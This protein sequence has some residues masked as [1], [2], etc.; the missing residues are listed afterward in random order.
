MKSVRF[1]ASPVLAIKLPAWRS[2]LVL[3]LLFTAFIALL[4]R[5]I[6]LQG[7]STDFLQTQGEMRYAR[8][9]D[10]PATRGKITD[11]NGEVLASSVPAWAIWAIPEDVELPRDKRTELARLLGVPAPELQKKLANEDRKFVYLKRQVSPATADAIAQL[12]LPGIHQRKEYR[13]FYP[14]GETMAHVVGFTNVEDT[15]QEGIE[16]AWQKSLAGQPGSRRVIK[17]RLGRVVE[18]VASIRVPHDGHDLTLSIDGKIQYL[19]FSHLKAAVEANRAKAGAIVVID[20]ETGEVLALANLPSYN[21]NDRKDLTG[22]QLR[23][24]VLTDTFEPGS[25]LKPF[26]IALALEHG[27]VKPDTVVQTA[28]GKMTIGSATISDSHAHGPLTVED[29]I[30]VSSN[31]GTAKVA[32]RMEPRE[33]WEMYTAAGFGQAPKWGFPGAVAGRVRPYKSWRPIEQA[34]MAYGY[35]LS[36]SLVQIARAYTMFARDGEIIPLTFF[37]STT[38]PSQPVHGTQVISP[39]VAREM[40]HMLE[41]AAGPGG[42]APKAQVM[43]YRVAGKTGTAHKLTGKRYD[44]NR[45]VGSFVGFAPVSNPR[46]VVAVMIDEPQAGVYYGGDVAAPVFSAVVG[47]T[48]RTLGVEPDSPIKSLI[49]PA[50]SPKEAL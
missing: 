15:G 50:D 49:I 38:A 10:M 25:T 12:N 2:R 6:W 48:L 13:R 19:A 7:F 3:F 21:P 46:I 40:R 28:P 29:I 34:T 31:I 32:L 44:G 42:T 47:G 9:L 22:A 41:M 16:L 18:D 30:K 8:T 1:H 27:V 39:T 14:E 33:M 11:R 17:D 35:G 37:K 23:N 26:T 5:A 24:R 36:V 45:Y 4:L 20:V 43:G